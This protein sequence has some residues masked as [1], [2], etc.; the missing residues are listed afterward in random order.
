MDGFTRFSKVGALFGED[1][2]K[3]EAAREPEVIEPVYSTIDLAAAREAAWRE[4]HDA[5]LQDAATKDTAAT[6]QAVAAFAEQFATDARQP[7]RGPSNQPK[8][9]RDCCWTVWR[10]YS[11]HSACA[12]AMRRCVRSCARCCR[13]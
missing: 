13:R 9:S 8:R 3:P 5:G 10:R 7:R 1:F 2:D 6:H 12:T 11:R 4:G